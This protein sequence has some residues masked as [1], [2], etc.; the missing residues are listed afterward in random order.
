MRPRLHIPQDEAALLALLPRFVHYAEAAAIYNN[1]SAVRAKKSGPVSDGAGFTYFFTPPRRAPR[2]FSPRPRRPCGRRRTWCSRA[3]S[4]AG[5]SAANCAGRR[6][7][8][9]QSRR[10]IIPQTKSLISPTVLSDIRAAS[11]ARPR[12]AGR[13]RSQTCT[14]CSTRGG[15][16][17]ASRCR[18]CRGGRRP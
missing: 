18:G 10:R 7:T 15:W 4:R 3:R 14:L 11:P 1:S 8:T 12:R 2:A 13:P 16:S 6:P 5:A 9:R 17:R